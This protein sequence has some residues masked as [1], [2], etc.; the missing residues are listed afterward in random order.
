MLTEKPKPPKCQET[1]YIMG[2]T[3]KREREKR[4]HD[5]YRIP[6]RELLK[7]KGTQTLGNHLINGEIS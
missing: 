6:E 2:R 7:R 3:K 5:G 4:N 1:L